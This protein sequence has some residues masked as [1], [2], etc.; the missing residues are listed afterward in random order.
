[1]QYCYTKI[2]LESNEKMELFLDSF[3]ICLLKN[4]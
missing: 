4:E 3:K 2:N 1:M